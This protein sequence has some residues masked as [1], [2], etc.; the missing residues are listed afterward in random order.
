MCV[1][2]LSRFRYPK[3]GFLG[4]TAEWH[5]Y[6]PPGWD[7]AHI[8]EHLMEN[9]HAASIERDAIRELFNVARTLNQFFREEIGNRRLGHHLIHDIIDNAAR[10]LFS[11]RD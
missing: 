1:Y 5:M 11:S 9:L 3:K 6:T 2:Q 7:E 10:L 4:L 8:F